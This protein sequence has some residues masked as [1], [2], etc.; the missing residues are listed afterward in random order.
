[1][2]MYLFVLELTIATLFLLASL[3]Y[4]SLPSSQFLMLLKELISR[5]YQFSYTYSFM[6]K[7][8]H[9]FPLSSRI[10]F[11][12]LLLALRHK[13][14][15]PQKYLRDHIRNAFLKLHRP[16][17]SLDWYFLFVPRV[18]KTKQHQ[19]DTLLPLGPPYGVAFLH[20][21]ISPIFLG[22][23]RYPF[24]SSKPF[25]TLWILALRVLLA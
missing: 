13:L 1:M 14:G 12:I 19:L 4:D 6:V 3:M 23:F 9:W 20:L 5:L 16:L 17:R 7:Q 18:R 8:I 21:Y 10:Q 11:R 22:L 15:V 24:L 25:S 2:Y